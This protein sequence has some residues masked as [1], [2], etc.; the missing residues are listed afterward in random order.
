M[1]GAQERRDQERSDKEEM[2]TNFLS[3][4]ERLREGAGRVG[5]TSA[6]EDLQPDS[7]VRDR[8]GVSSPADVDVTRARGAA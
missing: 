4:P 1:E 2:E 6:P 8:R 5:R 3:R 7:D